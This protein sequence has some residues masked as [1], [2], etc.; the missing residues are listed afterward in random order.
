MTRRL[1]LALL[2]LLLATPFARAWDAD[3]VFGAWWT[4]KHDGVVDIAPCDAGLCGTVIGVTR[5]RPDGSAELD[6]R[7]Q[8]RCHLEIIHGG[9]ASSEGVWDSHITNPDDEQTYTIELH[10]DESGRLRMRGY[11]AIP[12]LGETVFWTRFD[13]HVTPDCQISN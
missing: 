4:P 2:L 5:R 6:Q 10:V 13:G 1:T 7:G 12:L 11:I 9:S 3:S 8:S